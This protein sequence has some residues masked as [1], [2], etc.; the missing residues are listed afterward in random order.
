M[1]EGGT[2]KNKPHSQSSCKQSFSAVLHCADSRQAKGPPVLHLVHH[3]NK[4]FPLSC[5]EMIF[6]CDINVVLYKAIFHRATRGPQQFHPLG[7]STSRKKLLPLHLR[8]LEDMTISS[9]D[10]DNTKLPLIQKIVI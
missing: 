2:T 7:G 8:L 3:C 6:V 4:H 5:E 9:F 1:S 10:C